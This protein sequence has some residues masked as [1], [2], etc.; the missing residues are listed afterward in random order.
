MKVI[1]NKNVGIVV[2]KAKFKNIASKGQAC[3]TGLVI[4][5]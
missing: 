5:P 4:E 2:D 1:V 3:R